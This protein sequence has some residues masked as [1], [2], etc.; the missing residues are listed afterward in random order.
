MI[1]VF[2]LGR[3]CG[4]SMVARAL[5][6]E[7]GARDAAGAAAV[8]CSATLAGVPLASR[9]ALA[10][11]RLLADVPG[12]A[13]RAVGR[14]CLVGGAEPLLLSDTTRHHAPLVLDAGSVA[15]GGAP[16][17]IA[18]RIVLV[19][20]PRTDPDL[21]VVVAA[22]L[23]RVGPRPLVV[24]NRVRETLGDAW[25]RRAALTLPDSRMGAQLALGGR[26][27]RG[28]LGVAVGRLADAVSADTPA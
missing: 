11:A 5:G 23:A 15:V 10:L 12:A 24:V 18:D 3:G 19:A 6:A 16:A 14:L 21:D 4:A 7:L 27:P 17:A 20:T 1:A 8:A 2:G 25:E 13:T 28:A 9:S 26:E 22:G